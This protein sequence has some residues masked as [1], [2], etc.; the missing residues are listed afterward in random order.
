MRTPS[1]RENWNSTGPNRRYMLLNTHSPALLSISTARMMVISQDQ[2]PEHFDHQNGRGQLR[3]ATDRKAPGDWQVR[4]RP[5]PLAAASGGTE[6]GEA[7]ESG[8]GH[9]WA[10]LPP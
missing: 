8:E 6:Q 5:T 2:L 3:V 9:R 1:L 7:L 4:A 10:V